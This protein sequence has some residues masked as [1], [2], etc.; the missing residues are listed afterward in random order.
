[1]AIFKINV[2]HTDSGVMVVEPSDLR[3]VG[4]RFVPKYMLP[5]T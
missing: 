1:M 3:L 2:K 4:T 5:H